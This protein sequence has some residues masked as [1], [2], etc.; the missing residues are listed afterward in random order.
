MHAPFLCDSRQ[1]SSLVIDRCS[2][3]AGKKIGSGSGVT[4]RA[5]WSVVSARMTTIAIA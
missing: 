4:S 2:Y 5:A 3:L 1:F